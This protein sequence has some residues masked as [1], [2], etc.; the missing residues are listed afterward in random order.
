[1]FI[2]DIDFKFLC[3]R[4]SVVYRIRTQNLTILGGYSAALMF[5][6]PILNAATMSTC[7]SRHVG[8]HEGLEHRCFVSVMTRP[9]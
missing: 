6:R 1:M 9:K 4:L 5:Y 3:S 2:Y 8:L 7:I